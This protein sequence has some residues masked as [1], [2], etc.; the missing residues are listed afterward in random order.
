MLCEYLDQ[1]C[2]AYLDDIVVYSNSLE[3]HME[4]VQCVLAKLQEAGLYLKLM[5]CEFNMQ[6]ISFVRSIITPDGV[7][8]E[9][10]RVR[11]IAEW[12]EPESHR[13]I[14]VFLDFANFYCRF[15]SAF[16]KIAK[17]MTD[18]LKGGKNGRFAGPFVPTLAIR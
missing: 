12:P 10:D 3:E 7:E 15:I 11:A 6:Q 18:M 14:Q 17:P 16:S 2:I 5:K 8:I 13:D 9:P 4:H 1:V